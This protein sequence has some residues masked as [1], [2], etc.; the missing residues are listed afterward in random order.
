MRW[1]MVMAERPK[2]HSSRVRPE[3][4]PHSRWSLISG[5]TTTYNTL[6]RDHPRDHPIEKVPDKEILKTGK[7]EFHADPVFASK[8]VDAYTNKQGQK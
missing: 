2:Q 8:N 4:E 1:M 6:E 7:C 3:Y 5:Y